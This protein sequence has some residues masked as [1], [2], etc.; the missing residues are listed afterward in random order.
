VK[1]LHGVLSFIPHSESM[2]GELF[3]SHWMQQFQ[4]SEMLKFKE[5]LD[6]GMFG[7]FVKQKA[8]KITN[9]HRLSMLVPFSEG[10][11]AS[12]CEEVQCLRALL[13]L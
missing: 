8:M 12:T 11:N 2:N 3:S 1:S 9:F 7:Y 4:K 6:K 13:S 10:K 5:L